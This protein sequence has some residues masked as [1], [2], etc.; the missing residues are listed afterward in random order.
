MSINTTPNRR[1]VIKSGLAGLATVS[2]PFGN[3]SFAKVNSNRRFVLVVARG[4]LDGLAL[5]PPYGDPNYRKVRGRLALPPAKDG[6]MLPLNQLFALH[7]AATQLLPFWARGEMVLLPSVATSYQGSQH[8]AA[9]IHLDSGLGNPKNPRSGW[10]NRAVRAMSPQDIRAMT[11][12]DQI[13]LVLRGPQS[14]GQ[15][16]TTEMQLMPGFLNRVAL[17]YQDDPI[18]STALAQER[19]QMDQQMQAR[20]SDDQ[21][22]AGSARPVSDLS[23]MAEMAAAS[24][25]EADGARIAVIEVSGWDSHESQ[26]A[27]EGPLAR[28]FSALAGGLE[29]LAAEMG[30]AWR[31][32]A[33]IVATEFGRS[34]APNGQLGTDHGQGSPTMLLGGNVKGGRMIG[35]WPG[36]VSA[37]GGD[38]PR[39]QPTQDIRGLFKSVLIQ[40]FGMEPALVE[41]EVFPRSA[42]IS[43]LSNLF[44]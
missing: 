16:A 18:L 9:Q 15:F 17:L 22:A 39:L 13:P 38:M 25:R 3:L 19:S 37:T 6:G 20:A 35:A 32:T 2:L 41:R 10:L 5:F 42:S 11:T 26:G 31:D 30:D 29:T 4:G 44:S 12:S 36:L 33:V 14:S 28:K 8:E 40:H 7:P 21:K 23:L 1:Q 34:I 24:L 43:Q 27:L